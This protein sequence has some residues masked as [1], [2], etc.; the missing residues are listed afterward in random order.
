VVSADPDRAGADYARL[1]QLGIGFALE[2]TDLAGLAE[3]FG[4]LVAHVPARG[5]FFAA[6]RLRG[7]DISTIAARARAL[8]LPLHEEASRV[9]LALPQFQSLLEFSA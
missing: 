7:G 9:V 4:A 6:I 8:G 3:R 2:F 5:E 1:G